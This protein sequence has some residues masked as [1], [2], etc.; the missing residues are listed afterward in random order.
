MKFK[1]INRITLFGGS[2]ILSVEKRFWLNSQGSIHWSGIY[3]GLNILI[4]VFQYNAVWTLF[5]GWASS[6]SLIDCSRSEMTDRSHSAC[7]LSLIGSDYLEQRLGRL[8]QGSR[9]NDAVI[10]VPVFLSPLE[11][12]YHEGR[13]IALFVFCCI[14][15]ACHSAIYIYIYIWHIYIYIYIYMAIF[16]S[17]IINKLMWVFS[18]VLGTMGVISS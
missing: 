15:S 13:N 11:C 9:R 17:I 6:L 18:T 10:R 5:C 3:N 8:C 1:S 12:K 2:V 14:L 16:I 7:T 4:R